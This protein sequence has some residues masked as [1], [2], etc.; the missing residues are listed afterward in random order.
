MTIIRVILHH[1]LIATNTLVCVVGLRY[2]TVRECCKFHSKGLIY[3]I[4]QAA[5]DEARWAWLLVLGPSIFVAGVSVLLGILGLIHARWLPTSS[6][7]R[8]M[9]WASAICGMIWLT[10]FGCAYLLLFAFAS[11]HDL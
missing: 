9:L 7:N 11:I 10:L 8:D 4:C 1:F 6:K 5:T 3:S 2:T